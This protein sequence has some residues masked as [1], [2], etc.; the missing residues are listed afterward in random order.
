MSDVKRVG[1][2]PASRLVSL[3]DVTSSSVQHM[4]AYQ[5]SPMSFKLTQARRA[6]AFSTGTRWRFSGRQSCLS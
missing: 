6:H 3:H 2:S 1:M 5:A 4:Q